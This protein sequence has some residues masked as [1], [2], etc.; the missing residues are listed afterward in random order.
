MPPSEINEDEGKKEKYDP[1]FLD[2]YSDYNRVLRNWLVAFGAGVPATI[3]INDKLLNKFVV[4]G[5]L[6][7]YFVALFFIGIM[8]QVCLALINKYMNW[9][10][11]YYSF[12]GI[13]LPNKGFKGWFCKTFGRGNSIAYDVCADIGSIILFAFGTVILFFIAANNQPIMN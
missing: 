7:N 10:N 9:I 11:H 5:D 8:L 1:D 6:G 4:S 2:L 13:K 3:L 12:K